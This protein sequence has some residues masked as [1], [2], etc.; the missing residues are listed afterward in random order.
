MI[1]LTQEGVLMIKNIKNEFFEELKPN[2]IFNGSLVKG[3]GEGKYYMEQK[4]Y[5]RQ[6][7]KKLNYIPWPGTFNIRLNSGKLKDMLSNIK[8]ITINGFN[9]KNRNF[10]SIYCYPCTIID[11]K[12]LNKNLYNK[13]KQN[14]FIGCNNIPHDIEKDIKTNLIIPKRSGHSDDIIEIIAPVYLRRSLNVKE[15]D[16]IIVTLKQNE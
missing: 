2:V 12:L 14:G 8:P 3:F 11:N 5:K 15:N 10:G 16:E 4:G 1:K 6:F 13:L 7:N 9:E